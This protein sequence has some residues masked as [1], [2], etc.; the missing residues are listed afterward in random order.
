MRIDGGL[1]RVPGLA[2]IAASA[3][4]DA[5]RALATSV[6]AALSE[7]PPIT[8]ELSVVEYDAAVDQHLEPWLHRRAALIQH[9]QNDSS[10]A[11]VAV[12]GA[13]LGTLLVSMQ[14]TLRALPL[15]TEIAHDAE[16]TAM[17]RSSVSGRFHPLSRD[18]HPT[19][20]ACAREAVSVW[21]GTVCARARL[22]LLFPDSETTF[23]FGGVSGQEKHAPAAASPAF[24]SLDVSREHHSR[25]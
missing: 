4:S 12:R 25:E 24:R 3:L 16:L 6:T 19:L 2:P 5:E 14:T 20:Q 1:V 15:P 8:G 13:L 9:L 21:P 17:F 23:R 18:A 11:R 22:N 7:P 10:D